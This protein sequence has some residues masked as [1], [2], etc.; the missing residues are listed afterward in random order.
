MLQKVGLSKNCYQVISTDEET[1]TRIILPCN[2]KTYAGVEMLAYEFVN[3][4]DVIPVLKNTFEP[5]SKIVSVDEPIDRKALYNAI[6]EDLTLTLVALKYAMEKDKTCFNLSKALAL[7][8]DYELKYMYSENNPVISVKEETPQLKHMWEHAIHVAYYAYELY[9]NSP[10]KDTFP[11]D[12][13]YMYLI[14]L[15]NS[16]GA[17]FL[18]AADK[19]QM[20]YITEL[21]RQYDEYGEKILKLFTE[22]NASTY[23]SMVAAKRFGFPI[24]ICYDLVGWNGL[25]LVPEKDLKRVSIIHLAEMLQFYDQGMI[26][27]YQTDKQVLLDFGIADEAQFKALLKTLKDGFD[28]RSTSA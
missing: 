16:M 1:I 22:G 20:D 11:Q 18:F 23:V 9:K 26:G 15:M 4:K 10:Y 25:A 24:G 7:L 13:E 14:G 21:S 8:S 2:R 12:E 19:D 5:V 3:L 6:R 27:Y 17:V 28:S